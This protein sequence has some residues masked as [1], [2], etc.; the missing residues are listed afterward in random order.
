M[1]GIYIIITVLILLASIFIISDY[2]E[3]VEKEIKWRDNLIAELSTE[4]TKYRKVVDKWRS[5]NED[6]WGR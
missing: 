3:E 1:L 2:I 4:N 5:S 6:C